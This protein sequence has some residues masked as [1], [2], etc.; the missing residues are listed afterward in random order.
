M[1]LPKV[2][3][4]NLGLESPEKS[5]LC[6][7]DLLESS[8]PSSSGLRVSDGTHWRSRVPG[9]QDTAPLQARLGWRSE[10]RAGRSEG[11]EV[12]GEQ[13]GES[14][15]S[16]SGGMCWALSFSAQGLVSAQ[17]TASTPFL[18]KAHLHTPYLIQ[19]WY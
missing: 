19:G 6:I 1:V 9:T 15:C 3:S 5:M 14:R 16:A 4:T 17:T 12:Q 13:I 18:G 10:G 8:P 2:E 11:T 7:L